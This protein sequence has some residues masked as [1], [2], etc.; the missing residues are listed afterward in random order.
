[1]GACNHVHMKTVAVISQKGGSGKTTVCIHLAVAAERKEQTTAIVDL[2]PQA[3]SSTWRDVREGET[4]VVVSAQPNRLSIV[5]GEARKH[6]A[7]LIFIDTSPN[8]ETA[9][10]TAARS[11]DFVVIP[12]R[13]HLLDLQAIALSVELARM[14]QKPFAV[15][16]NAVPPKGSLSVD[17][18]QVLDDQGIPRAPT[19]LGHRAAFY[20]CLNQ[21]QV[22]QEYD[23]LGKACEEVYELYGWLQQQLAL[24]ATVQAPELPLS[25]G[26]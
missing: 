8:S 26:T 15:V 9:S 10:L 2:D 19:Q 16:L 21:G 5:L 24:K 1:M 3:S 4:P 6:G 7:Q 22:A 18:A 17:A 13:P 23:P 14:A 20:H 11:A 25:A 12:C